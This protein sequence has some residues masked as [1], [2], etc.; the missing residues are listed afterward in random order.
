MPSINWFVK[1]FVD[2]SERLGIICMLYEVCEL[3]D[4][5]MYTVITLFETGELVLGSCYTSTLRKSFTQL[6]LNLIPSQVLGDQLFYTSVYW[7][8]LMS[9][10]LL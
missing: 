9:L 4:V 1:S 2:V 7:S 5:F 3:G 10:R 8:L 6:D